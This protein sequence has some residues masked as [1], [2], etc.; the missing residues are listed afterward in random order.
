MRDERKR[1]RAG[2][3]LGIASDGEEVCVRAA[4]EEQWPSRGAVIQARPSCCLA[5]GPYA[6]FKQHAYVHTNPGSLPC[7]H[8]AYYFVHPGVFRCPSDLLQRKQREA[9]KRE[10]GFLCAH[11]SERGGRKI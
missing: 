11:V 2:S 9:D 5:Y 10:G 4:S 8:F 7:P 6:L 3:L 1:R